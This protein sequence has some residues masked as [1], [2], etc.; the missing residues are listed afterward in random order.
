MRTVPA[1]AATT[2]AVAI[3]AGRPATAEEAGRSFSAFGTFGSLVV[4]RPDALDAGDG[5]LSAELAAIDSACSRFRPDSE[6]SGVN[7][8]GGRVIKVSKLFA[9]ALHTAL[10]AAALT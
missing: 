7:R 4:T 1:R 3:A 6:L 5:L 10:T 2:G 9:E 8:A